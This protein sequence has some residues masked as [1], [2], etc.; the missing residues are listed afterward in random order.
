MPSKT[1]GP[2]QS[3]VRK[4]IFLLDYAITNIDEVKSKLFEGWE[5]REML[6]TNGLMSAGSNILGDDNNLRSLC[7]LIN[8]MSRGWIIANYKGNAIVLSNCFSKGSSTQTRS[9][10]PDP[11]M[12]MRNDDGTRKIF[13]ANRFATAKSQSNKLFNGPRLRTRRSKD[14]FD[15]RLKKMRS[16]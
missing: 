10:N 16:I 1:R 13:G 2:A 4:A 14:A 12:W 15:R 3:T 7:N 6:V 9:K 5:L 11:S 8:E